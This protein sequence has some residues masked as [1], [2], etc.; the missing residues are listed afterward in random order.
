MNKIVYNGLVFAD[1]DGIGEGKLT[2]ISFQAET[3]LAQDE[4]SVDTLNF[5]VKYPGD[6][7]KPDDSIAKLPYGTICSYYRDDVLFCKY[8]L[9]SVT[10]DD[11]FKYEFEFQS[12]IGLLDDTNHYGGLY[13]GAYASDIIADVI[14]NKI[15]YTIKPVFSKIKLYGWLPVAT[16]RANLQQVLFACGGCVK[17][18]E[19]GNAYITT[20]DTTTPKQIPDNRIFSAGKI[21][22]DSNISSVAVTEHGY[23]KL[24]NIEDTKLFKGELI[25]SDFTTPKGKTV[26]NASLVTWEKPCYDITVK[27]T[28]LIES[29]VN[30]AVVNA[31]PAVEVYGK[32]YLHTESVVHKDKP[33]YTGKEKLAEVKK[34][35]L[36]SLANSGSTAERLMAYYGNANTMSPSIILENERTTDNIELTNPFWEKSTGFIKSID[37][38]VGPRITKANC[39]IILNYVPPT[40]VGSRTLVSIEITTPPVQT[41]YATGDYFNRNG[42]VVTA[43]Y[44][45][46]T[47]AIVSNYQVTPNTP[48]TLND[49]KVTITYREIGVSA[50]AE[51]PITVKNVL[52]KIE[53]TQPPYT[54]DYYVDDTF[55]N[56]GMIV[57]A[58]YS[59]GSHK[60]VT[61]YTWEPTR[62]LT[63]QDNTITISYTED[64]VTA[65]TYQDITVGE[66]P[67]LV[68]IAITNPPDKT[69]YKLNEYFDRTGMLVT[70]TFA[71][72]KSR[73]VSGYSVSP[74]GALGKNDTTITVSYTRKGITKTATQP[75]TVVYLTSIVVSNPP[76]YTEYYEGNSFNKAGMVVTAIYSNDATKILS[77]TDYT[78]TPEILMM[79]M[80]SV[81]IS[82]TEN[83][84]TATTTQAVKV[85]YYPYDFTKS[86]VISQSGTYS[87]NDFGATHRNF[88]VIAISGGQGGQG[89][90][91]GV[92]GGNSDSSIIPDRDAGS[93]ESS[94]GGTGGKGGKGGAL[95]KSGKVI[96]GEGYV[97]ALT[98]SITINIGAAGEGTANGTAPTV[99]GEGG[100]TTCSF[101]STTLDS[102]NG[103]QVENGYKDLFS[104]TVYALDGIAG[105]DGAYGGNGGDG[106]SSGTTGKSGE[107]VN[108]MSGGSPGTAHR[109]TGGSYPIRY[110][111][112]SDSGGYNGHFRDS[113]LYTFYTSYSFDPDT[114]ICTF[115][116]RKAFYGRE[117]DSYVS[118]GG[119]Y[120]I[121]AYSNHKGYGKA[122]VFTTD[123]YYY[124]GYRSDLYVAEATY[125]SPGYI[126]TQSGGGGGGASAIS[127]GSNASGITGGAGADGGTTAFTGTFGSGGNAGNG[128]GGGGGAGGT[129]AWCH[130]KYDSGAWT[131]GG[132]GGAGGKGGAGTNGAQ[133]CVIIYY[134]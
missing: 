49:T 31:T 28:T 119:T 58:F 134:S 125:G 37:A 59:D 24:D 84:V 96:S 16:R 33:D 32:E 77:D 82:Y 6:E 11:K 70:A 74:N 27:G 98:D 122:R 78:V 97:D 113:E 53:I 104:E 91:D 55:D 5:A 133:G 92:A 129:Y 52:R 10:R 90:A 21:K 25:G 112:Q 43:K 120:Y 118:A 35:T 38:S 99:G 109:K 111:L 102:N 71:D 36:V 88:R 22:Y 100:N 105:I 14:G 81:T 66:A 130:A 107:S 106:S 72:G 57:E 30:Y 86:K 48:L 17:R 83:G 75:I 89:G 65:T 126:E 41:A 108:G 101:G 8:Y 94:A 42:M 54:V 80:T 87:L 127:A 95:G 115:T 110:S 18:N 9:V 67:D 3:S 69:V 61:T 123:N 117:W 124:P 63:E 64:G 62:A 45:D 12:S 68:S 76:T 51:I 29:D 47:T 15:P 40:V 46:N 13:S 50:T 103:E 2:D 1:E 114:G 85:N 73:I 44:D 79:K 20:L 34:A 116:G 131:N 39:E 121:D 26:S 4:L 23:V 93:E 132:S 19:D 128:G 56:T 7:S 60:P